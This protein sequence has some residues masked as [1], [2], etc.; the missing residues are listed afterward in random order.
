[1]YIRGLVIFCMLSFIYRAAHAQEYK[2]LILEKVGSKHRITYHI[3]DPIILKLKGEDFEIRDEIKDIS[4]SVLFLQDFFIPIQRIDYVKTKHTRGFL[5]PSNGPKIMIAGVA[6]FA[7]D[8]LNQ[9]LIQ[10][11]TYHINKG[12]AI[13]SASMVGFGG[14]LVSFKYRKF[15]ASKNR[16]IRTLV[17]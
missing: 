10:D 7:F 3:G 4:D 16:R 14:L 8:F 1:M 2:A 12:V 17:M 6:L 13:V 11:K 9:T 15:R 5:S